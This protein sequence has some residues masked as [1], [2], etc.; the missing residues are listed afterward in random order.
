MSDS[1]QG[2]L[3]QAETETQVVMMVKDFIASFTPEEMNRLSKECQPGKF[4]EAEDVNSYSFTLMR[5]TCGDDPATAELVH[6]LANFFANAS[7]RLSQI[8]ARPNVYES[9][10]RQSA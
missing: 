1:W 7:T 9:D 3:E 5:H 4:F 8:M 10:K 2:R 6:K